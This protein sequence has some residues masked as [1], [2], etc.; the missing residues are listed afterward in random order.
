M[1]KSKGSNPFTRGLS[2]RWR[3]QT[4]GGTPVVVELERSPG[5]RWRNLWLSGPVRRIGLA[6]PDP[7]LLEA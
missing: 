5:D 3:L 4:A 6:E 2:R 1:P 7:A